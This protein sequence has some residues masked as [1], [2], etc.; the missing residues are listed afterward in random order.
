MGRLVPFFLWQ[1]ERSLLHLMKQLS[2]KK[3]YLQV[4]KLERNILDINDISL[5]SK[6]LLA[7]IEAYYNKPD[8]VFNA[9][10][11]FIAHELNINE[12][13]I[14]RALTELLNKQYIVIEYTQ[15]KWGKSNRIIYSK[16]L[17]DFKKAYQY[18]KNNY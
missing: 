14:K 11:S 2:P 12:R 5:I 1:K 16:R 6:V 9:S 18:F 13:T 15:H 3:H 10:N 17:L 8:K 4:L 7:Y